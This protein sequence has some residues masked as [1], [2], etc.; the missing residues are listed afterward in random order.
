MALE[1]FLDLIRCHE[2]SLRIAQ[3][4]V[5]CD[6]SE[7]HLTIYAKIAKSNDMFRPERNTP[8]A[9]AIPSPAAAPAAGIASTP[10]EALL[11]PAASFFAAPIDEPAA[12]A[13]RQWAIGPKQCRWIIADEDAGAG[14]L[15]CGALSEP[16]RPFCAVHCARAYM[17][18]PQDEA[19]AVEAEAEAELE[20]E[21]EPEEEE[22]E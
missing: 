1:R 2:S 21:E 8:P 7:F 22:A 17:E 13:A 16:H 18:L 6:L 9:A 19:E 20:P 5:Y 3:T 14:A 10:D 4:S 12:T 11:M 15:M